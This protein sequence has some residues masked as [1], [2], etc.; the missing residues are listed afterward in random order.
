[1]NKAAI[2]TFAIWARK[3]LISDVRLKARLIGISENGIAAPLPN[4]L[5]DLLFFDIGKDN[6]PYSIIPG[7]SPP[8]D[9]N[10]SLFILYG[11]ITP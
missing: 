11:Y 6:E 9:G 4:S 2:K 10:P 7:D 1:M 3:Q 5:K 8:P